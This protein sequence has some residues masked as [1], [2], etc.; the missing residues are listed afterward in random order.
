MTAGQIVA[1]LKALPGA[2]EVKAETEATGPVVRVDLNFPRLALYGL[3]AADVLDTVQAAFAGERVGLIYA[4][5]RVVD[6][7]V[8]A[9]DTLRRDPEAVGE[10]LLRSTS[11]VSVPLKTVANVYLTDG[12]V[13]IAHEGGLRRQVITASPAGPE[14]F[15]REARKAI[16]DK[17]KLPPGVFVEFGGS[18]KAA[19]AARQDLVVNYAVAVF[20]I[21]ALL[22]IAFDGLTGA[23]ILLSTLFSFVGAALVVWMMGG[24]LSTGALAG[25]FALFGVSI[26]GAI[27]LFGRLDDLL[28]SHQASWSLE[29]V[30]LA[31]RE[32]LTPVLMTTALLAFSLAPLAVEAGQAGRE[33]LG[34]MALVIIGGLVT[35]TLANLVILPAMIHALWRAGYARLARR[36]A[37]LNPAT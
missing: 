7:A 37:P 34:P 26:R 5:G 16:G 4:G 30:I 15:I 36:H 29:T 8:S 19:A 10:L 17:I 9:Q 14:R 25:F 28:L 22:S 1:A 6:L 12:R 24:T 27:L 13:L 18:A 3:S 2:R 33:I 23:L 32:R 21:I 31:S 35:G 20:A 11:G